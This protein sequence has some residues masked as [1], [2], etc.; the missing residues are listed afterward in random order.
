MPEIAEV[1]TVASALKKKIL[2]KKIKDIKILYPKIIT[3]E[4]KYFKRCL[5]GNE[6][7]DIKTKGKWLLFYLNDYSYST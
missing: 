6:I 4:S 5:I 7:K 2:N 1:R 3:N